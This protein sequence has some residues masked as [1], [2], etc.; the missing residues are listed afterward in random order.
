[1]TLTSVV[2]TKNTALIGDEAKIWVEVKAQR[3]KGPRT[4]EQTT[5]D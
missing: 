5:M 3:D 4:Q 2:D 1:V